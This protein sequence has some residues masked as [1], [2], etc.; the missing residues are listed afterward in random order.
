MELQVKKFM[1]EKGLL[2]A[3]DNVLVGVSGGVDSMALLHF[4]FM[5]QKAFQISVS[6]IT[7]N[8]DLRGDES[9]EDYLFV[10]SYCKQ[11]NIPFYGET[12]DVNRRKNETGLST[13]VVARNERYK[14]FTR[15]FERGNF[16]KLALAHHG[17]DQIE[18]VLMQI[19]RG[20]NNIG[21]VGIPYKRIF[22]DGYLIRP[23]LSVTKS[24]L[25]Q[26]IH[27]NQ[28]KFR[29]DPSNHTLTYT[30]NRFRK[31]ILPFLKEEN[32]LVHE[33][34]QQFTEL[35]LLEN[36]VLQELSRENLNKV[37]KRK[38]P[39]Q[40]TLYIPEFV[41]LQK[42]L[43]RRIIQLIL[44]YLYQEWSEVIGYSHIE[45][46]FSL[47]QGSNPN[48]QIHLP[49]GFMAKRSYGE[50][51][52]TKSEEEEVKEHTVKLLENESIS[53][54]NGDNIKC[55]F[56]YGR[57][58]IAKKINSK[59]FYCE[60]TSVVT[61]LVIRTRKNGDR[62]IQKGTG[63]TKKLKNLFIDN[64]IPMVK[65]DQWPIITDQN[66]QILWVP[67]LKKGHLEGTIQLDKLYLYLEY[68]QH[69]TN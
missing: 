43:Q 51:F 54:W 5:N 69:L 35:L 58:L 9:L 2:D 65:R 7:V 37:M 49:Q 22:S 55:S 60:A 36:E 40:M 28:I 59:Q 20:I 16:T 31:V 1:N 27:K 68:K 42:S 11:H 21:S 10:Q 26:Y 41:N 30:R 15:I 18:T 47:I 61:P 57:E 33:K 48:S 38:T 8:H 25:E 13:E 19:T 12:V 66:N 17:D 63:G 14:A 62:I 23:F 44:N 45:A 50:I 24:D 52:I 39:T 3:G 56:L 67:L 4:L 64:K 29:E 53:L 32:H 34:F 46:I 6:A